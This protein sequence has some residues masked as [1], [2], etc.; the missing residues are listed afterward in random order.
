M[1]DMYMYTDNSIDEM[2]NHEQNPK[3]SKMHEWVIE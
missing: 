3:H 1:L 2:G